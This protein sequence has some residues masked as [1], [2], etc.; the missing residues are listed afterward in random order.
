M[1]FLLSGMNLKYLIPGK[2]LP[3]LNFLRPKHLKKI[4]VD[5]NWLI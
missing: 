3:N 1:H 2:F 4:I 5:A